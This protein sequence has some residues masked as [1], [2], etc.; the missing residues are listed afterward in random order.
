MK[1]KGYGRKWSW[2]N[3]F[4]LIVKYCHESATKVDSERKLSEGIYNLTSIV[5]ELSY[6]VNNKYLLQASSFT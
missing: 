5:H 2:P 1:W 6:V 4:V 3:L